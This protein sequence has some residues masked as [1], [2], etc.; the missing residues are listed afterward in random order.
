MN[1]LHVPDKVLINPAE[2]AMTTG[3]PI[4]YLKGVSLW[5]AEH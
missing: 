1:S 3:L 2:W 5:L 4:T